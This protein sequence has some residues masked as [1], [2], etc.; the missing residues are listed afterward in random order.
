MLT[1]GPM[2]LSFSAAASISDIIT[3][4]CLLAGVCPPIAFLTMNKT[5]L[6]VDGSSYLYRAYHAMPD[7]RNASGEPTGALYG[8]VNML[9]KLALD[10]KADYAACVFDARG[11]TFR[12]DIYPEY[13]AHRPPMPEDLAAQIEPIH[14][15]VRALGWPVLAVEGVEADD[16][17][18]TL[19][20][21]A[22]AHGIHT[23]VSTGDKDLAQLVNDHVTLVNTM[24]GE[25]LDPAGVVKKFGVPASRIVDY[26]MLIGDTVDNVPGVPKVG[27]KTA[28]KWLTEFGSVDALVQAADSIKGVAGNNLRAAIPAGALVVALD[29]RGTAMT[30]EQWSQRVNKW[31][32]G[33]R[34]VAFLIGGA[35]GLEPG[36]KESADML[37]SL[38]SMTLPHQLVRVVLAEQLYRA[39]SMLS[40][41]PYHRV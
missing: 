26:L 24:S 28:V 32:Q 34:E 6:L 16:V 5:L 11:K 36:L 38:S 12:E 35:D 15:A 33:G 1:A 3:G 10:H 18:G 8:V 9:R 2:A 4:I 30:T 27:P 41:H 14:Q 17:I 13:K 21:M 37:L 23:I 20:H 31:L 40:N 22:T 39:L 29:E 7:L 19:A 25:T